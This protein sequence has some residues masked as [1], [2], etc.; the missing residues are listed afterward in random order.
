M[1][2][3]RGSR[4]RAHTASN[5]PYR[6]LLL[7]TL[8]A[9]LALLSCSETALN[10]R[11]VNEVQAR[12]AV[13]GWLAH[14]SH[15]GEE[16]GDQI[17]K[18]VLY[19]GGV[20][21][22]IGYYLVVLEPQGWLKLSADDRFYPI[23]GFAGSRMTADSF[24]NS[25]WGGWGAAQTSADSTPFPER[26]PL[27]DPRQDQGGNSSYSYYQMK[28]SRMRWKALLMPL[29]AD[30]ETGGETET[31]A[32]TAASEEETQVKGFPLLE[33]ALNF[34]VGSDPKYDLETV[35]R[36]ALGPILRNIR[37]FLDQDGWLVTT[38]R[39]TAFPALLGGE[40]GP[41]F[42]LASASHRPYGNG[43]VKH[44]RM[45][46]AQMRETLGDTTVRIRSPLPENRHALVLDPGDS[47]VH[48]SSTY[49]IYRADGDRWETYLASVPVAIDIHGAS[50]SGWIT[51]SVLE[52]SQNFEAGGYR[53]AFV[54][55]LTRPTI[56]REDDPF[57]VINALYLN[58]SH[59]PVDLI[60][61]RETDLASLVWSR[62]CSIRSDLAGV[63]LS[64]ALVVGEREENTIA[65]DIA[66]SGEGP[67]TVSL[68]APGG[69]HVARRRALEGEGTVSIGVP[70][71]YNREPGEWTFVVEEAAEFAGQTTVLLAVARGLHEIGERDFLRLLRD[72]DEDWDLTP[73]GAEPNLSEIRGDLLKSGADGKKL[74]YQLGDGRVAAPSTTE[75]I[76][77]GPL[78]RPDAVDLHRLGDDLDLNLAGTTDGVTLAGWFTGQDGDRP[79]SIF[80]VD[81]TIYGPEE[82][83]RKSIPVAPPRRILIVPSYACVEGTEGDDLLLR[84]A[85]T[86]IPSTDRVFYVRK[87]WGD[88]ILA[89][90]EAGR[91]EQGV[92][93]IRYHY[94][95]APRDVH[96]S[97]Q[98]ND[99]LLSLA[100]GSM[101]VEDWFAGA[102]VDNVAFADGEVWDAADLERLVQ[103]RPLEERDNV[104]I[105]IGP[106]KESCG[107][108]PYL[109]VDASPQDD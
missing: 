46:S 80:F 45:V 49:T 96:I 42:L 37:L 85:A 52:F 78:V 93:V 58:E 103:G 71:A 28:S 94:D 9:L 102:R 6:R 88:D 101:R 105:Q 31:P 23:T 83:A 72:E 51:H 47:T 41:T 63:D 40:S 19:K 62:G 106:A 8:L 26:Y 20:N 68:Y 36:E 89:A 65:P 43:H 33:G 75:E 77:F 34:F 74:R 17:A 97:R 104:P 1:G 10:A 98:E 59:G 82:I 73:D 107:E 21:G 64:F 79:T 109:C 76:H 3:R 81:G 69:R 13:E 24:E 67:L 35:D 90:K 86:E 91:E 16:M 54:D 50:D 56:Y 70:A 87:G 95:I 12:K 14:G 18:M 15:F 25:F 38:G 48:A 66:A 55:A 92:T 108:A 22:P 60:R 61:I 100:D 32:E 4:H 30:S 7:A 53:R 57:N 84:E 2:P 99:L 27:P 29:S 39:A 44:V 5:L 11:H